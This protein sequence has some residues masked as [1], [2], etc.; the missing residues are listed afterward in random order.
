M[1]K[2]TLMKFESKLKNTGTSIFAIMT[3]L[4]NKHCAINLSQGFPDFTVDP[5]L[6]DNVDYFMRAGFN[7]YPPMTGVA[8]LRESIS[9][10]TKEFYGRDYNTESEITVTSG[11]TEALFAAISSTVDTGDEVIVFE[12]A[13]DSYVPSILLNK[14]IPVYVP[15][16]SPDFKINWEIFKSKISDKTKLIILNFPHNPTGSTLHEDDLKTLAEIIRD[17]N[18][19]I[20]SDEVYEHIIFDGKEHQSII[21]FQELAERSFVI[22]S[23]G[24]TFHITG[25]K[26]GYCQAPSELMVEFR[27]VHQFLTYATSA[28][29]QYAIAKYLDD[30]DKVYEV[31]KMYE[32][33]RNYFLELTKH[34]RFKPLHSEG[35]YFQTLDYSD[36]TDEYDFDFAVRITKEFGVAS[37]PISVFYS[38][39]TDNKLLRFCFA[40]N[41]ETLQTAAERICRI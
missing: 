29:F 8:P 17:K 25:W 33:K 14:G 3:A 19:F 41:D 20:I 11:A 39:N 15:L 23:F 40:K 22:S 10:L 34:S 12:P 30:L 9:R 24:K 32:Q 27:K 4:A 37:I 36:I 38:D 13:Y 7:Q 28:P 5:Q 18:I 16:V 1:S 6:I 2:N 21:K 31:K 35:T 26:V